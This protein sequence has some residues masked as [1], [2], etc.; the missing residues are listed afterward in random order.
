MGIGYMV[1]DA[2]TVGMA[3]DGLAA[4]GEKD[5]YN[6]WARYNIAACEGA[7]VS[8]QMPTEDGSDNMK[9]GLGVAFNLW[10]GLYIEP[11]YSMLTSKDENDKRE[12]TF[13]FGL[14]FRF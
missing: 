8:L 12:G 1:S 6:V 11:N 2:I 7:Y 10:N 13:N 3:R 14:S 4:E 5:S 9:V